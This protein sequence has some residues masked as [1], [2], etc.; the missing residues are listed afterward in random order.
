MEFFAKFNRKYRNFVVD[1]HETAGDLREKAQRE[2][3]YQVCYLF[4]Y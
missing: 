1:L 2:S 3:K 4:F